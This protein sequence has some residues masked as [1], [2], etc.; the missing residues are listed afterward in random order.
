MTGSVVLMG[1]SG[2]GKTTV[3]RLLAGRLGTVFVDG[4][5]LHPPANRAAMAAG[6]PLTDDDRRPWLAAVAARLDRGEPIVLA[7]S[8]L[9]RRYRDQ[10]AR[11]GVRLVQLEVSRAQLAARLAARSGHFFPAGLLDSQLDTAEPPG[12]DETVLTVDG[13]REPAT[14]AAA[15]VAALHDQVE[16][17]R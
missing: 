14:V 7:C 5:D 13:E 3:G 4:D 11:P 8:G 16:V 2:S 1:V 6:R 9:R 10:L 15:I 17:G 12:S